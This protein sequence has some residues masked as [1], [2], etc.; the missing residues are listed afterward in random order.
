MKASHDAFILRL[1]PTPTPSRAGSLQ[2]THQQ[3]HYLEP[4][5]IERLNI[6]I[7][8]K[9]YPSVITT[10]PTL[11]MKAFWAT[12]NGERPTTS[13]F[14]LCKVDLNTRWYAPARTTTKRFPKLFGSGSN[15]QS[16][17]EA[18]WHTPRGTQN[19]H[20]PPVASCE[21]HPKMSNSKIPHRTIK[22]LGLPVLFP[23]SA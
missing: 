14:K 5:N 11:D 17:V 23:T 6:L 4:Q 3:R 18:I 7:L 21:M 1:P 15:L 22:V 19:Y 2:A 16:L 10:S 20:A 8:S 13:W 9:T 12:N